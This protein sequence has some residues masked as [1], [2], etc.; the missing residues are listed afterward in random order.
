MILWQQ[1]YGLSVLQDDHLGGGGKGDKKPPKFFRKLSIPYDKRNRFALRQSV[2]IGFLKS[3]RIFRTEIKVLQKLQSRFSGLF[4]FQ[5][6]LTTGIPFQKNKNVPKC[7]PNR[8]TKMAETPVH[9][10]THKNS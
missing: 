4:W 2:S 5:I 6:W 7:L 9:T 3:G 10:E 8:L 1:Y